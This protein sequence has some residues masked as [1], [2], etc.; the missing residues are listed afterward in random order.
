L[1]D[2]LTIWLSGVNLLFAEF[3][4]IKTF[5][6]RIYLTGEGFEV[7]DIYEMLVTEPWTKSIPF[8]EPPEFSKISLSELPLISDLSGKASSLEWTMPASLSILFL[9]Q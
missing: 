6:S 9:E 1:E 2:V 5:A 7:P 8:R 3:S 4:G